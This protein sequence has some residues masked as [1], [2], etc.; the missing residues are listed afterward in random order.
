M[1]HTVLLNLNS[2]VK[3]QWM[4]GGTKSKL[5]T[6]PYVAPAIYS[7]TNLVNQEPLS[8]ENINVYI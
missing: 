1:E 3:H 6:V 5:I 2:S 8:S 4:H 7:Y